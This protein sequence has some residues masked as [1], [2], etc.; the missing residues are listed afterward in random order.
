MSD[1]VRRAIR[2]Y[3]DAWAGT[4]LGLWAMSGLGGDDYMAGVSDLAVIG[5]ITFAAAI[6][7]IPALVS[8][9]KNALEDNGAIPA[10][11]KAPAS[12]GENPTP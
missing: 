7:A 8:F 9:I 2:T 11:L 4:F 1:A 6:A 5:K 10:L 12:D 3:I